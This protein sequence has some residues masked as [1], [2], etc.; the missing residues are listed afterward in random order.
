VTESAKKT[1]VEEPRKL[2]LV[3]KVLVALMVVVTAGLVVGTV[4]AIRAKRV[5]EERCRETGATLSK[6]VSVFHDTEMEMGPSESRCPWLY[7]DRSSFGDPIL[8]FTSE[9]KGAIRDAWGNPIYYRYPGPIHKNGWDLISCGPNG[10]FEEGGGDDI[11]L[12]ED[13]PGGIAT[14]SSASRRPTGR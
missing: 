9:E 14:V 5:E 6:V 7:W 2:G 12:G 4:V 8:G 10:V 1:T 11:V 3:G 13:L